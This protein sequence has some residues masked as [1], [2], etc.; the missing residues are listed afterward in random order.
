MIDLQNFGENLRL[1]KD[2]QTISEKDT[3]VDIIT[4]FDKCNKRTGLLEQ[5]FNVNLELYE[6]PFFLLIENL[7]ALSYGEDE[8]EIILWWVYDRFDEEGKLMPIKLD[9]EDE[10]VEEDVIVETAE[11]LWNLLEKLK[12]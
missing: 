5:E 12:N 3:F 1:V 9:F 4:I 2:N 6:N 8:A 11:E 10:G 7:L